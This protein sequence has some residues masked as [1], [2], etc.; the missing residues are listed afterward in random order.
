MSTRWRACAAG[1]H[2]WRLA[3]S[4]PWCNAEGVATGQMDSSQHI[5]Q[6]TSVVTQRGIWVG[7]WPV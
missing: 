5:A 7:V 1:W 3:T 6:R 4:Q 2:C